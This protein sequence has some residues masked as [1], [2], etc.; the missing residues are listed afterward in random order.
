MT[1]HR[2]AILA[3]APTRLDFGGGWTDVPPYPE[4]RG[5]FVCAVAISRRA[6]VR[7][8]PG[9]S[10][11]ASTDA[12]ISAALRRAGVA[13]LDVTLTS[14]FPVGAGLGGSS[15]AGVALAAAMHRVRQIA[16]TPAMLAEW[17]RAV[18]VEELG[19]AGGR[20]DHYAAA[21]GGPL[22][23]SFG[24]GTIV[25]S[26]AVP[27]A[28]RAALERQCLLY[29]TGESRISATTISAVLDAYRDRVPRVV[30]ALARMAQLAHGMRDALVAGDVSTLAALVAEH[31]VEQRALH[32]GITTRRI[33]AI[34]RAARTAGATA[35][36][37]LGASG[38]GCVIVLAPDAQIEG[39]ALAVDA[40]AE[41]L[42]W[43]IDDD[44]V[45]VSDLD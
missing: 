45:R 3:S 7:I 32:P 6:T 16:T 1:D 29:Y 4:E 20:Q 43:Q 42:A 19:I 30:D 13:D 23:L 15:A 27:S 9:R 39:V 2:R 24:T 18:E 25:E 37:A 28:A 34:E 8:R 40:L 36:K 31:W 10:T 21:F 5:G 17:S 12:L 22:G 11:D 14:D 41:R 35:I 26:L 38:G 44:G 33:D